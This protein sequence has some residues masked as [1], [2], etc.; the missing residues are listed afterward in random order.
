MCSVL[1]SLHSSR[2]MGGSSPSCRSVAVEPTQ[3]QLHL[4]LVFGFELADF[5]VDGHQPPQLAVV[6]KQ[7]EV[8]VGIIH[9]NAF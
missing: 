6:K 2:P 3:V 1:P 7:V 9:G 5:Q 8:V 4:A